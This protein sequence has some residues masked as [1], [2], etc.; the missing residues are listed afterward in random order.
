[1]SSHRASALLLMILILGLGTAQRSVQSQDAPP[2]T[3]QQ[4]ATPSTDKD[5]Q[6]KDL[7]L[8][9]LRSGIAKLSVE[10][11]KLRLDGYLGWIAPTVSLLTI[12]ILALT[13]F[14]QRKT[15]LDVQMRQAGQAIEIQK[16]QADQAIEIQ[17]RQGQHALELKIA[18]FVMGSRSPA[19]ALKRAELLTAL[20]KGQ[21]GNEF[22]EV[23]KTRAAQGDFPGDLGIEIRKTIFDKLSGNYKEPADV[24]ELARR[25]FS[26]DQWLKVL[27]VP[28]KRKSAGADETK[29]AVEEADC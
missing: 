13:V 18:D 3:V 26:G 8:Q 5:E 11:E 22:L 25:I 15:A 27:E 21:V 24:A 16:R 7:E 17:T 9:K 12:A 29:N 10:S 28:E 19:Q 20:Y 1:M 4:A 2:G 23:V 6:K 14:W